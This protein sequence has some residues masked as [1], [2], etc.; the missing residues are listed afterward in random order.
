MSCWEDFSH[1]VYT[2]YK[3]PKTLFQGSPLANLAKFSALSGYSLI[4]FNCEWE[5]Y[6][7]QIIQNSSQHWRNKTYDLITQCIRKF[8]LTP[9]KLNLPLKHHHSLFNFTLL[10]TQLRKR[11]NSSF[12]FRINP[13]RFITASLSGANVLFPLVH[14]E[15]FVHIGENIGWLWCSEFFKLGG[16]VKF[17]NGFFKTT[18]IK[19]EFATKR[20][21]GWAREESQATK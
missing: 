16:F 13:Q 10:Q 15:T 12:T 19:E 6:N 8:Q 4:N 5:A 17:F 14:C 18:L 2:I 3:D 9:R 7:K 1:L 21:N 20:Q 11:S